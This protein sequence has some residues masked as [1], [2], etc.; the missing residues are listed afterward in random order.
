MI[1]RRYQAGQS[2]KTF[3]FSG[4]LKS[5][6]GVLNSKVYIGTVIGRILDVLAFKG[7]LVFLPKYLEN[8]YGIPQYKVGGVG[9]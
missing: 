4:F 2:L 9:R 1:I 3:H 8:H 7:Y 5:Y 6:Q